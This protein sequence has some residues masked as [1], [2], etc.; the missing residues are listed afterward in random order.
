MREEIDKARDLRRNPT[1]AERKL[2]D[3]LRRRQI[4]GHRFRR[5]EVIG[6][7]IVDF[8]CRPARLIVELDGGQHDARASA[9]AMRTGDLERLGYRVLR[10]W[11]DDVLRNMEGVLQTITKA[12][13]QPHPTLPYEGR[14][15]ANPSGGVPRRT[16]AFATNESITFFVPALSNA[17]S[18][19]LPSTT[20]TRP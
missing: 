6:T 4:D 13:R 1:A 20:R 14:A 16:Q 18:N 3:A 11:N 15:S 8:V 7:Y 12:L 5:Q 2:W 17:I 10:F 19:L 9:D